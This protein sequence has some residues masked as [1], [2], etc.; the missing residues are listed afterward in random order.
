MSRRGAAL[1]QLARPHQNLTPP[2]DGQGEKKRNEI[3]KY[4]TIPT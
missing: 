4:L 2:A 1:Q 3:L